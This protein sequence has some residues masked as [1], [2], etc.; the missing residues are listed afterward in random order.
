MFHDIVS[1]HTYFNH[2]ESD[3]YI[4]VSCIIHER[5]PSISNQI[6]LSTFPAS[7]EKKID[8]LF[9]FDKLG[10]SLH[11]HYYWHTINSAVAKIH[12]FNILNFF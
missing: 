4:R 3:K 7:L 11:L 6:I 9:T 12:S 8:L 10:L 2:R 5:I 1:L